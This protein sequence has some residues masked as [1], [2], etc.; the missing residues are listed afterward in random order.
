MP[1]PE[2]HAGAEHGSERVIVFDTSLRDGE[3]APGASMDLEQKLRVAR[4]LQALG[5]DVLEAGF[6]AASPGDFEAVEAVARQVEGPTVCALA[7]ANR[8]DVDRVTEA[9]R[10]AQRK[11]CHVFLATSP[12]HREFKLGFGTAEVVRRAVESVRHARESFDDVEYSAEDAARTEPDFLC[13]VVERVIEAGASTINIPDTV[14][15]AIPSQFAGL[16]VHLRRRVR[17]IERVVL[18]V[19]CHDD[20]GLA[21]ANTLAA[22]EAGARQV[23]CTVNGIGERAGNC[24]LEEVV[25]ALRTRADHFQ[26]RTGIRTQELCAAS[27]AVAK[28]S[29]FAVARNKAVVGQNAFAH[30][31]GIHQH[32][33]MANALTYEIMRPD[34][35][36][37]ES[38]QLVLGKHSGRH[39]LRHRLE[40][41]G[42]RLDD[43]RFERAF[44]EVKKLAD[45]KKELHDGDLEA[46]VAGVLH[47]VAVGQWELL[48]V[49]TASGAGGLAT[50]AVTLRGRDGREV[51]DAACAQSPLEAV[52]RSIERITGTAARVRDYQVGGVDGES[53]VRIEVQHRDRTYSGTAQAADVLV[54]SARAFVE[55]VN[56][57][58]ASGRSRRELAESEART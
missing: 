18:S 17:G 39:L 23:E 41:L 32:G 5:V 8:Q 56:R 53:E 24:S 49:S 6:P 27:R 37:F 29:G 26:L 55:V 3:Q 51:Q 15:Y 10:P 42:Y 30:E 57:I 16:I 46:V 19:H 4:A 1:Q 47:G 20:L 45:T 2:K 34:D 43:V 33:M 25:M 7:R 11:R 48:G 38:S 36:G 13:E 31:A 40:Q 28:A 44:V 14:G 52:F 35:V 21:V 50:A 58:D 22:V 54:G 9:L 12:I